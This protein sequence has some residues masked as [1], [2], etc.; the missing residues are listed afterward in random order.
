MKVHYL[1]TDLIL[2]SP[3]DLTPIV[4]AFGEDVFN[5][6]NGPYKSHFMAP[7]ETSGMNASPDAI[8]Q[9]FCTLIDGFEGTEKRLCDACFS[10]VFDIGYE[11]GTAH[12]SYTDEINS[13]TLK[14]IADLGC[15]VRVT[16]YPMDKEVVRD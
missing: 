13:D 4:E 16:V 11:G 15:A 12:A 2:E 8:I 14:R 1:N 6:Y 7:F 3:N 5:L 10:K 9:F